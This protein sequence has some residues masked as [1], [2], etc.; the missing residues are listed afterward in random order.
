MC[1]I[2]C[3]TANKRLLQVE[4]TGACRVCTSE[5]EGWAQGNVFTVFGQLAYTLSAC[6]LPTKQA[7][8]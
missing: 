2:Y 4:L 3:F 1:S 7:I 8:H 6:H 5:L